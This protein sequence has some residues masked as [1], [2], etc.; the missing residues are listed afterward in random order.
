[1]PIESSQCVSITSTERLAEAR[2]VPS[3]GSV[4]DSC[5]CEYGLAAW[6]A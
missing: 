3:V 5:D 2:I 1:M 6:G 4:G